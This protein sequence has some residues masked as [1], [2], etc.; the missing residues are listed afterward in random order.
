MN[1]RKVLTILNN[2]KTTKNDL[3]KV[4]KKSNMIIKNPSRL[5]KI[6]IVKVLMRKYKI[7]KNE[8]IYFYTA[9]DLKSLLLK[10]NIPKD[11]LKGR[12]SKSELFKMYIN[13]R[14]RLLTSDFDTYWHL[15]QGRRDYMEDNIF[16]F[17]NNFIHFSSVFDGH[18]GK[19]CSLFLKR[20]LYPYFQ[21]CIGKN[22]KIKKS[23][24]NAYSLANKNFLNKGIDSG[25]TCNT[26]IIN[27]K[28]NNFFLANVG[29]SRAIICYKNGSV[30]RISIDHKPDN[31]KEKARIQKQG[32]FVE[33]HRVDGI[34]AMSRSIGDRR[35]A[36]HLSSMPDVFEGSLKNIKYIVQASDGLYDVMSNSQVCKYINSLLKKG[37]S[38]REI[39]YYLVNHSIKNRGSMDNV[40]VIITY[41]S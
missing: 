16:Y 15:E 31:K 9:S 39:P 11:K 10:N 29:D 35:I 14:N 28:T 40:S 7:N 25:S 37:V 17:K 19:Q 4:I 12:K 30:K 18:G 38:K 26:L 21:R 3:I 41:I 32:G 27:K 5:S 33:D 6:D 36:H 1:K 34:L 24:I 20:N 22:K 13:L 8:L 23:I 2:S